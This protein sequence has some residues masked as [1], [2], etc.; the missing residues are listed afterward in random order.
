[1]ATVEIEQMTISIP[2]E[3][4]TALQK[5]A[6]AIGKDVKIYVEDLLKT[7]VL[8]PSIDEILAPFRK[9]VE[10]SRISDDEFDEFVGEIREEIYREKLTKQREK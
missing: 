4:K 1:M 10:A 5:K 2:L 8:R 9:E 3:V 6:S 7:Q